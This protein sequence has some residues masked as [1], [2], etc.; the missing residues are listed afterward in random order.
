MAIVHTPYSL[1]F[2][3]V[4]LENQQGSIKEDLLQKLKPFF[5]K[6]VTELANCIHNTLLIEEKKVEILPKIETRVERKEPIK[7][8]MFWSLYHYHNP[9]LYAE[10]YDIN[11]ELQERHKIAEHFREKTKCLKDRRHRLTNADVDEI[12][13]NLLTLTTRKTIWTTCFGDISVD[14]SQAI[15]FAQYYRKNI[16]ICIPE[17][18]IMVSFIYEEDSDKITLIFDPISGLF[19]ISEE[20]NTL[21]TGYLSMETM[22]T[23]LKPLSQYKLTELVEMCQQLGLSPPKKKCDLYRCIIDHCHGVN[24]SST[25]S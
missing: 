1:M 11:M 6:G 16:Y 17:R 4:F 15:V 25:S 3:T 19:K 18:R 14:I 10:K 20:A 2:Q 12:V 7:N 8:T 5:Y 23:T 24:V 21:T 13:S 22:K 9:L